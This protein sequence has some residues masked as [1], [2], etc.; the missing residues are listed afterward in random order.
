MKYPYKAFKDVFKDP[1]PKFLLCCLFMLTDFAPVHSWWTVSI[2]GGWNVLNEPWQQRPEC[3]LRPKKRRSCASSKE[4]GT[5]VCPRGGSEVDAA[6][7]GVFVCSVSPPGSVSNC[8][9]WSEICLCCWREAIY[10]TALW[11]K[12]VD[13]RP[14]RQRAA[15]VC[16]L[17]PRLSFS[18][19]QPSFSWHFPLPCPSPCVMRSSFWSPSNRTTHAEGQE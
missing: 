19:R 11:K 15:N 8:G 14:G 13:S 7:P 4:N 2:N 17:H 12:Q 1:K 18:L 9:R 5:P 6:W 3:T 10:L 16:A